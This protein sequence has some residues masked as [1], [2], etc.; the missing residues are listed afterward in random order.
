MKLLVTDGF[1]EIQREAAE[2]RSLFAG[3]YRGVRAELLV[4]ASLALIALS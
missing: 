4:G 3:G 1:L 2:A